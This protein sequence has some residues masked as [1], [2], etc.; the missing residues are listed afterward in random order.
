MEFNGSRKEA[1]KIISDD[2]GGDH[3]AFNRNYT[4]ITIGGRGVSGIRSQGASKPLKIN[5]TD[6]VSKYTNNRNEYIELSTPDP[7]VRKAGAQ[8]FKDNAGQPTDI[9]HGNRVERTGKALK[10]MTQNRRTTYHSNMS[11]A[12]VFIGDDPRNLAPEDPAFNRGTDKKQHSN[13]DKGIKRLRINNTQS[14][15]LSQIDE[16]GTTSKVGRQQAALA[17]RKLPG[18]PTPR[19]PFDFR[20]VMPWMD[21]VGPLDQATGG[22][23]EST[24]DK[25]VNVLRQSLGIKPN[26][27]GHHPT[28][29]PLGAVRNTVARGIWDMGN[30]LFG[31][32]NP[33][34]QDIK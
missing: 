20:G 16:T 21:Y 4:K 34:P 26:P 14:P 27:V 8:V 22:H 23:V 15:T 13:M 28:P 32:N 24:I 11:E 18:L 10:P 17:T 7:E 6:T 31:N 3:L 25:G 2:F 1:L 5:Y 29:D 30:K 19:A 9:D 33:Y 12:G